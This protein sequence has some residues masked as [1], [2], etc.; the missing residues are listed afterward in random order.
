MRVE[1]LDELVRSL[2]RL[3]RKLGKGI[4]DSLRVLARDVAD[5]A[6]GVAVFQGFAE[7]GRSGRG[8]GAMLSSIKY[9]VRAGSAYV[10]VAAQRDGYPYPRVYE[11]GGG[12]E[13]SFVHPA[14][15]LEEEHIFRTLEQTVDALL[16]GELLT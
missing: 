11:Y 2:R 13:R 4:T 3:D 1:G 12:G 8:T 6:K 5:T 9:G 15:G 10:R 14:L 16:R 7:P